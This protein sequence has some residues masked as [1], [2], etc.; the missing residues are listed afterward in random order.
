MMARMNETRK[1]IY[2]PSQ[3]NWEGPNWKIL[4]KKTLSLFF[5]SGW[6]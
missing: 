5:I 4:T 3:R 6:L 2:G 1:D